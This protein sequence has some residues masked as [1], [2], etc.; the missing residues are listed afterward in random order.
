[1]RE[2]IMRFMQGRYGFDSFSG[3]IMGVSA[4]LLI[5]NIFTGLWILNILVLAL[6]VWS[7]SRILSRNINKRY[8]EN[9][10]YLNYRNKFFHFFKNIKVYIHDWSKYLMFR[11]PDCHQKLRVPRGKGRIVVTCPK[12]KK[13]IIKKS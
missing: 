5:I 8:D 12:C 4:V 10:T 11:C 7:Y 13:Q 6:I 9:C 2:K 3:F 1:M